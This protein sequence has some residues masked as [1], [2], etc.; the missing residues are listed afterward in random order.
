[1]MWAVWRHDRRW[2]AAWFTLCTA[3]FVAAWWDLGNDTWIAGIERGFSDRWGVVAVM[4]FGLGLWTSVRDR[5][6][7]TRESLHQRAIDGTHLLRA[8]LVACC[9]V[10]ATSLAVTLLLSWLGWIDDVRQARDL[11]SAQ[12]LGV[13]LAWF[14]VLI[15]ALA[16]GIVAGTSSGPWWRAIVG[17]GLTAAAVGVLSYMASVL[18]ALGSGKDGLVA[19]WVYV[20][21]N[22]LLA[23]PLLHV[24]IG[25]SSR[26]EDPD[27]GRAQKHPAWAA[28]ALAGLCCVC[29]IV[30]LRAFQDDRARAL[31]GSQPNVLLLQ[32]GDVELVTWVARDMSWGRVDEAGESMG[33]SSVRLDV[34]GGRGVASA[35]DVQA[36]ISSVGLGWRDLVRTSLLPGG[37]FPLRVRTDRFDVSQGY[38]HDAP[39]VHPGVEAPWEVLDLAWP[40][41]PDHPRR[42][43]RRGTRKRVGRRVPVVR[44]DGRPL[45]PE[46]TWLSSPGPGVW[47]VDWSDGTLWT[48][49]RADIALRGLLQQASVPGNERIL[50]HDQRLGGTPS[51]LQ[52][53]ERRSFAQA[54][55]LQV[56]TSQGW[57]AMHGG[58][59]WLPVSEVEQW[60]VYLGRPDG[61]KPWGGTLKVERPAPLRL[62][63]T[64][65]DADGKP[66]LVHHF[67]PRGIDRG[68][69]LLVAWATA[70]EP[71]AAVALAYIPGTHAAVLAPYVAGGHNGSTVLWSLA[72]GTLCAVL[73]WLRLRRFDMPASVSRVWILGALLGG[74]TVLLAQ[75]VF[76]RK[77][78]WVVTDLRAP[79]K[80]L[81]V[82]PAL[83]VRQTAS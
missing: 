2:L 72:L 57:F 13:Q 74:L 69:E 17:G 23:L 77:R 18:R 54:T 28:A 4:A 43:E 79:D 25:R 66:I 12:T 56:R 26:L 8:R 80:R 22:V 55:S 37:D 19:P 11:W 31:E 45:G 14:S 71:A 7:G 51:L 46:V 67:R 36:A 61:W 60:I 1:M 9:I 44:D 70:L 63:A 15:P 73:V 21:V 20:V 53:G 81:R 65:L 33:A 6:A 40:P 64:V 48:G 30:G 75:W 29:A 41:I 35:G 27:N 32:S 58:G 50:E 42:D 83:R 34:N 47:V 78:A 3:A 68:G 82:P 5:L 76:V 10:L 49:T 24:G 38:L 62:D 59:T 39:I 16:A 52:A